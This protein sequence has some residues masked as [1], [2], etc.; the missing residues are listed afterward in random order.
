MIA[1][2]RQGL[3]LIILQSNNHDKKKRTEHTKK[4]PL[5]KTP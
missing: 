5:N 3:I 1:S 2:T 4:D